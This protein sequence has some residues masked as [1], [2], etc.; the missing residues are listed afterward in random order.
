MQKG[1]TS[2]KEEHRTVDL[3]EEIEEMKRILVSVSSAISHSV[4]RILLHLNK[5][6]LKKHLT[7]LSP[8]L[9][10]CTV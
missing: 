5:E 10:E 2:K 6:D 9:I 3:A 8:L 4:L 7:K 1:N